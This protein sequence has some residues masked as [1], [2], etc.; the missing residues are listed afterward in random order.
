MR[1]FVSSEQRFVAYRGVLY[2]DSVTDHG[3]WQR[4]LDVFD[5]VTI[6]A[7]V[8]NVAQLPDG[9]LVASGE[10]VDYCALP[11]YEGLGNF[12]RTA[13][14]YVSEMR[15]IARAQGAFLLRVPGIS[16]NIL[17]I[18][19]RLLRKPFAVEV[20][21]DPQDALSPLV[22]NQWWI[23][24]VRWLS[25]RL[26][27]WQCRTAS[28]GAAYVTEHTL[29]KRYAGAPAAPSYSI[30]DVRLEDFLPEAGFVREQAVCRNLLFVGSLAALYKGQE[31]L[32]RALH[33]SRRA[34]LDME[35]VMVGDGRYRSALENLTEELGLRDCVRFVG[36]LA[37]TQDLLHWLRWAHLFILPSYTEGMPRAMIEAMACGLPCLGTAVG[38][39][40]E[41]LPPEDLVR[42][43]NVAELAVK[44]REVATDQDRLRR[45]SERNAAKAQ[46]FHPEVLRAK[47][48][49]FYQQVRRLT[50][51]WQTSQL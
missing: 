44:I 47:R 15:R 26:Q 34:G 11:Y 37:G 3:F 43:G 9:W 48:I 5:R 1:V 31:I 8:K 16:G 12:L 29:Q 7:R 17:W 27:Q 46:K 14:R 24:P 21:G 38:G 19:L 39:I 30:S 32:L 20:V 35:L 28:A 45:M 41:L 18:Q 23:K 50:A 4:Y 42:P 10:R 36:Q 6:V 13:L 2:V 33:Q 51:D 25:V 22:W 49:G 40:P